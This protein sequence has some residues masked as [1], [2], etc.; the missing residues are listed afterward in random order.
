MT[1]HTDPKVKLQNKSML[2]S[3]GE[4][5]GT[6]P[7][8]R[9]VVRYG[10]SMGSHSSHWIYVAGDSATV[11]RSERQGKTTVNRVE[12]FIDGVQIVPAKED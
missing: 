4:Y 11:N 10:I 6:L 1:S 5:I 7:D 3:E 2:A 12:V 9:K 8:G